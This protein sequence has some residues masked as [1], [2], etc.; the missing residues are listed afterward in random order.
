MEES[1]FA[2]LLYYNIQPFQKI[3]L[4]REKNVNLVHLFQTHA[5]RGSTSGNNIFSLS[6]VSQ[7]Y[8]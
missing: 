5:R 1:C 8:K 6:R 3:N 2:L 4:L 7:I